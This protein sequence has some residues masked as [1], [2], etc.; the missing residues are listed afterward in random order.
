MKRWVIPTIGLVA[1]VFASAK[2]FEWRWRR[3]ATTPPAAPAKVTYQ[4]TVAAVGLVEPSSENISVSTPVSGLVVS[5]YVKAGDRVQKG[6]P[7]FSRT[8]EICVRS[9]RCE[10]PDWRLREAVW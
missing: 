6:A 1:L 4:H 8:I 5:V 3:D 2:A 9:L 7:L 10:R